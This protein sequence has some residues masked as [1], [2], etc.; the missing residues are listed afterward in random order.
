MNLVLI[1]GGTGTKM[2]PESTPDK[3]KQFLPFIDGK[4]TLRVNFERLAKFVYLNKIWVLTTKDLAPLVKL[5]LPEVDVDHYVIEPA[6]KNHGPAIGLLS[7]RLA[8]ID[9]NEPFMI[10]QTDVIR[11]PET[12]FREMVML[13]EE[14]VNRTGKLITA[15]Y[16]AKEM[17]AGVDYMEIEELKSN[18]HVTYGK[19]KKWLTRDKVVEIKRAVKLGKAYV[20]ATH[21]CWRPGL[22]LEAIK[23]LKPDWWNCLKDVLEAESQYLK[24]EPGSIENEIISH[25]I[26]G[27]YVIEMPFE[28]H[29]LGTWASVAIYQE[30]RDKKPELRAKIEI[31]ANN[32]FVRVSDE[33]K[34]VA[35][36]GVSDLVVVDTPNGLLICKKD[37]SGR[38]GEV[39]KELEGL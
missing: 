32:N 12:A 20:H 4:S 30:T 7:T 17:V 19:V 21:I 11:E 39:V 18:H 25:K 35:L 10:V 13:A 26:K 22:M 38:V 9:P 31:E 37:Q 1:C 14:V 8:K 6:R 36:I 27:G 2:W 33:K 3:P 24:M 28:W 15:G 29:D 5:E 23:E 16:R 34:P